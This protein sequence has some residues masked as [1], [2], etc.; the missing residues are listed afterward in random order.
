MGAVAGHGCCTM[1]SAQPDITELE[2]RLSD[3][4]GGEQLELLGELVAAYQGVR[5]YGNAARYGARAESLLREAGDESQL[6]A[7]LNVLQG[8][9]SCRCQSYDAGDLIES[10]TSAGSAEPAVIASRR[11]CLVYSFTG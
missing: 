10:T 3:S 6:A 7:L 8:G 5:D 2:V 9:S 4:A 1:A 11:P